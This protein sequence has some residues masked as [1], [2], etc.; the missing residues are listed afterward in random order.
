MSKTYKPL[1]NFL[2]IKS[3]KI[4]GLG[5]FAVE[6]IYGDTCLGVTHV[7]DIRF[8]DNLIRTPLGGFINHSDNPNCIIRTQEEGVDQLQNGLP[9]IRYLHSLRSIE[10]G[11]ELLIKYTIYTL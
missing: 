4:E 5:I 9:M 6:K 10:S 3:S 2:T 8:K 11:E 1:P 7:Y